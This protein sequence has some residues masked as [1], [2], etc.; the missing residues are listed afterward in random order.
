MRAGLIIPDIAEVERGR[1]G[2]GG[3]VSLGSAIVSRSMARN[4]MTLS[5]FFL[6]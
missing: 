1:A 6:A 4:R 2:S 5:E 3:R